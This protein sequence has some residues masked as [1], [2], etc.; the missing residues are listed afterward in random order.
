MLPVWVNNAIFCTA[1]AGALASSVVVL[2]TFPRRMREAMKGEPLRRRA[3][4][5]KG[6]IRR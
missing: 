6:E 5:V 4:D 2:V 1:L 3:T